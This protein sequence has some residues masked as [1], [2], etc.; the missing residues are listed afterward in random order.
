[1]I[2]REDEKLETNSASRRE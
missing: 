1:L 2:S